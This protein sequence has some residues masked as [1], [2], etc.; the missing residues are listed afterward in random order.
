MTVWPEAG[1]AIWEF[2]GPFDP[3]ALWRLAM[4]AVLGGTIGWER[5]RHGRAA[6][7]RTHLILC[8]GCALMMLVS[9]FLPG[10]FSALTSGTIVRADPSRIASQ[11]VAGLGFLGAGTILVLGRQ[12]R[13]LTTAASIWVTAGIGLA[14][15]VGYVIPAI[16]AWAVVVLALLLL[17]EL[18]RKMAKRDRYGGLRLVFEDKAPSRDEIKD[19]L[20]RHK[21]ELLECSV[22][23]NR[24]VRIFKIDLRYGFNVD[25][26]EVTE[27]LYGE[28]QDSGL[29]RI[30][31]T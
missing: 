11:V 8:V 16:F 4:A 19:I 29:T 26:P 31:W 13:G 5:E 21:I 25:F 24:T 14:V 3:A 10:R 28:L 9:L 22:D 23:R 17:G 12:I 30:H 7:L 20:T 15:G 2:V 1:D 18:E 6:G 27:D